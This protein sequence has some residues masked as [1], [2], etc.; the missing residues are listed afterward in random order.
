[1]EVCIDSPDSA[2]NAEKG[3]ATRVELCANLM[4]GGTTPSIGMLKIIKNLLSIPVFVMIRPRGGDFCYSWTELQVMKEDIICLREAGADGFVFGLL[5]SDGDV[6]ESGCAELLGLC[7]PLPT[8]FHRAIDMSRDIFDSLAKII[9]LGFIRVLSS[10][11]CQTAHQGAQVLKDMVCQVKDKIIVMPGG[12]ITVDN[13]KDILLTTKAKEFHGSARKI[14]KS[15]VTYMNSHV[16][17]GHI[18]ECEYIRKVTSS[19]QVSLFLR[20]ARSCWDAQVAE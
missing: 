16:C 17:M 6:D 1:M 5:T 3:G 15:S 12:G 10:G 9:Q 14:V 2:Q 8:T 20:I 19:G 13:L 18:P 7:H 4:E 11:G